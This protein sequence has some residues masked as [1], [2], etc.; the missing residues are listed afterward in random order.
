MGVRLA[1]IV[2]PIV[3]SEAT[4]AAVYDDALEFSGQ[5]RTIDELT[6]AVEKKPELSIETAEGLTRNGYQFSTL[7]G[8]GTSRDIIRWAFEPGTKPG[9]VAPEVYV[10]DE[11]SLFYNSHY[12]IP[13]LKSVI[14]PGVS[15]LAEVKQSFAAQ[16]TAKKKAQM[17]AAQITVK[18][19][20]AVAQQFGVKVDTFNNVNFNMSYLEGLGNENAVIGNVTSLKE[21]EVAGPIEGVNGVY[22]VKVIHRTEASLSTDIASFRRQLSAASRGGVDNRVMDALKST[23]SIEDNRYKFY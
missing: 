21:G 22:M 5:N 18:D 7:G 20:E 12:V 23:A 13:A 16:V 2:E 6:A 3:P 17:L 19:L 8:G 4:Q 15:S 14:K 11:P 9:M 10:Y 1:Y